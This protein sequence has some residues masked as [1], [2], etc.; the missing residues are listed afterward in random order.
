MLGKEN[1]GFNRE[2]VS[3]DDYLYIGNVFFQT[4]DV[5]INPKFTEEDILTLEEKI[6]ELS[7]IL[8]DANKTLEEKLN[9][10]NALNLSEDEKL[11]V[12]QSLKITQGEKDLIIQELQRQKKGSIFFILGLVGVSM[13]MGVLSLMK[14]KK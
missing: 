1:M 14:R 4:Q 5:T 6:G 11:Q 12:I 7:N 9:A 8:Q 2:I 13:M 3:N 10:I